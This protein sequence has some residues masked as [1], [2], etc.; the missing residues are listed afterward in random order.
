MVNQ[1]IKSIVYNSIPKPI[2]NNILHRYS[3][4]R[5]YK[6]RKVFEESL[7]SDKWLEKE[8]L[9]L[10]QKSFPFRQKTSYDSQA[11][12]QRGQQWGARIL[13]LIPSQN[14]AIN[15]VLEIGAGQGI[16]CEYLQIQGKQT[17]AIDIK[18]EESKL[19]SNSHNGVT[20]LEMDGG[21]LN[22]QDDSF[23]LIF[24]LNAFEHFP[25]PEL[26]FKECLRVLKTG[27]YLYLCFEPLYMSP[28]GLHA[29]HSITFPYC[30][31]LFAEETLQD[32]AQSNQLPP[33]N[34]QLNKWSL[35][36]YRNLWHKYNYFFKKIIY[37]EKRN[38]FY[39]DLIIEYS[40][41][42]KNQ[43]QY[44]DNLIVSGIEVLFTKQV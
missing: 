43:T 5:T 18:F 10:L 1:A 16:V 14:R 36:E 29:Y 33:V 2:L 37:Q 13:N 34:E 11:N 26:V 27:G 40:G 6:A 8:Q 3:D 4:I 12:K 25:N 20:Y 23:D 30:Q 39:T 41:L 15:N 21:D 42:F 22:F 38:P 35:E 31:F 19:N 32:F 9:E 7:P 24:S 28:W 44:F 17:T